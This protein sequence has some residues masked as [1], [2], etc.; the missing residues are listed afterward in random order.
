MSSAID[1]QL[2]RRSIP[3][4]EMKRVAESLGIQLTTLSR[5]LR[6]EL[7]LTVGEINGIASHL[8]CEIGEFV[9][10]QTLPELQPLTGQ[11][12]QKA[13][14]KMQ[15][16]LEE[17]PKEHRETWEAISDSLKREPFSLREVKLENLERL[18]EPTSET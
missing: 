4:G 10:Q 8:N 1:L 17:N 2:I 7:R 14:E 3:H 9:R 12:K 5:K 6:G 16:R 18:T 11:Q 15:R 13:L